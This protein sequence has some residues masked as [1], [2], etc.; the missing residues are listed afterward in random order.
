MENNALMAY[1]LSMIVFIIGSIAVIMFAAVIE[2]VVALY[3]EQTHSMT[4]PIFGNFYNFLV[5]LETIALFFTTLSLILFLVSLIL[6]RRAKL[7]MSWITL[8]FP[9]ILYA[10]AYGLIGV[11]LV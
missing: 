7:K 5:G 9:I 2:P 6:A 11:S 8:L 3:H 1:Y 4:S 10:F